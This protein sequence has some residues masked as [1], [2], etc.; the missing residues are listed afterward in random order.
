LT[1][2]TI[3]AV[4]DSSEHAGLAVRD[5]EAAG[6]PSAAITQHAKG[7]FKT[8]S[9]MA[10]TAP[11]REEGFWASLFGSG[12]EHGHDTSVYDRSMHDGSTIVTVKAPEQHLT[13]VMDI[14]ERHN[15]VDI[16]ERAATYGAGQA[17]TTRPLMRP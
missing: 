5:L 3:V 11:V 13:Q 6:V 4:Y 10:S 12:P 7:G 8:G 14:L 15:P 1:N 17:T 16:E 2:D 9:S